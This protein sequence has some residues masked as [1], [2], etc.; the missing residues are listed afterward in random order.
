MS[1]DRLRDFLD[2]V[3]INKELESR[4]RSVKELDELILI[5]KE[6]GFDLND[7]S[8]FNI[9]LTEDELSMISGSGLKNKK[10]DKSG[11]SIVDIFPR[12]NPTRPPKA[13]T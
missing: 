10:F 6:F 3:K 13:S 11:F 7:D 12:Y 9:E 8:I 4:V 2:E 1:E 5:A